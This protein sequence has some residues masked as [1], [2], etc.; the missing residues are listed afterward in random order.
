[1]VYTW[2]LT[3]GTLRY[4]DIIDFYDTRRMI[5]VNCF[6]IIVYHMQYHMYDIID[7]ILQMIS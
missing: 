7:M 1:V 5:I 6:D 4:Y 3:S 2:N